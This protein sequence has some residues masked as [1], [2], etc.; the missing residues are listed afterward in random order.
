MRHRS[1]AAKKPLLPIEK[2]AVPLDENGFVDWLV[3]AEPGDRVIY[4][5]GHLGF[6]RMPSANMLDRP[7]RINLQTVSARVMVTAGQE[8]VIPVQKRLGPED[9]LYIAVKALPGRSQSRS[10]LSPRLVPNTFAA[11]LY[12]S[13]AM[14][15]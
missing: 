11:P 4:Y 6:D 5:R 7:T 2:F 15:A 8:L 10:A 9:Y 3:D 14:A 13:A 1:I 12:Q